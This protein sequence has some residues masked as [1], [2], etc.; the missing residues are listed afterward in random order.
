MAQG[1]NRQH[2]DCFHGESPDAVDVVKSTK[3]RIQMRELPIIFSTP[4]VQALLAGRKTQPRRILKHGQF[5]HP[6]DFGIAEFTKA[7]TDRKGDLH[8]GP[9]VFGAISD[10]AAICIQCPYGKPGDLLY[11]RESFFVS[12]QFGIDKDDP[13]KPVN[14]IDFKAD[15]VEPYGI[16]NRGG[17]KPSIHMPKEAARIWLKV[18]EVRVERLQNISDADSIAEGIEIIGTNPTMYKDYYGKYHRGGGFLNPAN[19]FTSLWMAING[20]DSCKENPWL[21]VLEFEVISTTGKPNL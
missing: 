21:W 3:K 11:V 12:V 17:W 6:N 15:V 16:K 18:K 5:D 14:V 8:E 19:S 10:D 1:T 13:L 9:M 4:M 7:I 20:E 2:M